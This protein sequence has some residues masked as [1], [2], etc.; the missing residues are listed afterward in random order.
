MLASARLK[1]IVCTTELGRARQFYGELLELPTKGTSDGAL[2]FDVGG[3][4]LLVAP[5]PSCEPSAHTVIGFAVPDLRA[6]MATLSARGVACERFDG[7]PHDPDGIVR[8]PDGAH[9]AWVRDP[10]GN[11][12]SIVEYPRTQVA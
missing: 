9:V 12:L 6:V 7:L 4:D 2:V 5:V 10:D 3:A 8:S 1:T 11:I